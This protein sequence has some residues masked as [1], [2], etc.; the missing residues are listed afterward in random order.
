VSR[1][2]FIPADQTPV[3]SP[4][5]H[6][7]TLDVNAQQKKTPNSWNS[8]AFF[9][10]PLENADGQIVGLIRLDDHSNGLR[11]DIAT[12]ES[13][14]VF[15]AQAALLISNVL[16]QNELR[17]K[18]ESLSSAL[19]RQQKLLDVAKNDLP[20]LLRKDLEQTIS[21]HNLDRRAQRV[22]AGL[23][24]TESVSRQLDANS[25]LQALGR[26]TLTQ[27]SMS[28]ALVAEN[29]PDGP[30]LQH[31]MGSLPRA[32]NV[33][34]LFGQRDPLRACLQSGTPILI[35]NLDENEEWRDA[36]LLTSLRAK[37][38]ICLP[39]LVENKPVAA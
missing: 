29:T 30:H 34:A 35:P 23:A 2:Y 16:R 14:E 26:E 11:P 15:A 1:S 12:I 8:E 13:V 10:I 9:L 33:E 28:V 24:I 21:L 39:V 6:K 22:R 3:M 38:V 4:D 37:G 17:S 20:I 27:L 18:M 7:V 25:A 19:N 36:S 32:T 31:V 5:L